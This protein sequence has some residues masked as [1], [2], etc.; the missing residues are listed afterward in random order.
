MRVVAFD[1]SRAEAVSAVSARCFDA[2]W[3]PEELRREASRPVGR[4][5]VAERDGAVVGYGVAHVIAG[6]SEV[7]TI[8]VAPEHRRGGVGRAL[9]A[10]LVEGCE[11]A[12]LEVRAGDAAANGLYAAFGF[13]EA[14]R[15]AG[16]YADGEDAVVMAWRPRPSRR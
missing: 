11:R 1:P 7:I 13:V 6:E 9:L 14:G 15:R 8:G 2:P 12:F 5:V 10:A 16:Y 4:V 3:S